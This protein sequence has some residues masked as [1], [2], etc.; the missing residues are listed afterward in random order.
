MTGDA[1][2]SDP[3]DPELRGLVEAA[4]GRPALS[5]TPIAEARAGIEQMLGS[6]PPGPAHIEAEDLVV[7]SASGGVP[8]RLHRPADPAGLLV[9]FHGGSWAFGGLT[10][11]D[12]TMRHLADTSGFAILLADYRLAPEHR[13]PA[14][15][16]DAVATVEWAVASAGGLGFDTVSVGGE[17]AG[18]NLAAVAAL[19]ARDEGWPLDLQ[20]LVYPAVDG[21]LEAAS[22]KEY[23]EGYLVSAEDVRWS[24]RHYGLGELADDDDW[25]ISP[26]AGDPT[27]LAPALIIS[28]EL[29]PVADDST[30]YADHLRAAGVPVELTCYPGTV[31]T[32]FELR[33]LSTAALR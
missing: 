5:A 25:R 19:H 15:V 9:W 8:A 22:L 20:V 6:L 23:A 24:W 4:R 10:A 18:G 12:R 28:A 32:F 7:P 13:F 11:S 2:G 14:A 17:S 16:E 31:H 1:L 29:D 3:V 33:D 27:G 21:R 30:A 26:I